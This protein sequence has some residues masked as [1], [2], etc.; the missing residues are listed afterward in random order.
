[1][2]PQRVVLEIC[3]ESVAGALAAEVGGADRLEL[4]AALSEG[5]L[6]PSAGLVQQ[7]C[8]ATRLPVMMMI[9]PR[10]GSYV[11]SA[12][13]LAVMEADMAWGRQC[14]VAGFVWG[15][16]TD[17]GDVDAASSA[18]LL[19]AGQGREVTFHRAIDVCRDP[20]AAIAELK[21]LSIAR[22]LTSGGAV[23]APTGATTIARMRQAA[24]GQLVVMAGS[25][26]RPEN[27]R[28]LLQA[29]GVTELHGSASMSR[30]DGPSEP[31]QMQPQRKMTSQ[32]IVAALR[33]LLDEVARERAQQ[34]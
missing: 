29:T 19:E 6:T 2:K 9:R 27:A 17:E 5:G 31:G 32:V 11:Y 13:E 34:G 16:L 1:M 7:V 33:S 21:A 25:G 10:G 14:G 18:R 15:V 12:E 20:V 8:R 3:V 22:V 28:E 26:V 23:D 4:C 30:A 24:E